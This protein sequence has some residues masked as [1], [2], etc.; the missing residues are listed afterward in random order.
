MCVCVCVHV[1]CILSRFS[2]VP[3]FVI[4]LA[5]AFHAPLS[6]EFSRQEHLSGLPCLQLGNLP[7]SGIHLSP[8]TPALQADSLLVNYQGSLYIINHHQS[9]SQWIS[10]LGC[11]KLIL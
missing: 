6:M 5:E 8:A 3:L 1:M 4:L 2:H 11:M 7:G 9:I 10:S